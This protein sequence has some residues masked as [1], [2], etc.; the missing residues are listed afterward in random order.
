MNLPHSDLRPTM[1]TTHSRHAE[2][3]MCLATAYSSHAKANFSNPPN[4]YKPTL[5]LPLS[6]PDSPSSGLLELHP[7]T[8]ICQR[9][10]SQLVSELF[11][12]CFASI[13]RKKLSRSLLLPFI[14]RV[15]LPTGS[16]AKRRSLS[17]VPVEFDGWTTKKY[18][19]QTGGL[20]SPRGTKP[21]RVQF[22]RQQMGVNEQLHFPYFPRHICPQFCERSMS[23]NFPAR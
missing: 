12:S 7:V 18:F 2:T 9:L 1:I 19:R 16:F 11:S 8:I 15:K 10:F 21:D 6:I 17:L 13:P 3:N 20:T 22:S 5:F 4:M 14:F 23:F